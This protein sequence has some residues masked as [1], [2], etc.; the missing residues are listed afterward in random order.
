MNTP[1]QQILDWVFLE[2]EEEL[3]VDTIKLMA[4]ISQLQE[5]EKELFISAFDDGYYSGVN[6]HTQVLADN[7][8]DYYTKTFTN[9]SK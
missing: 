1:L 4:K 7:G 6:R 8:P 9:E 2:T 5:I 3:D